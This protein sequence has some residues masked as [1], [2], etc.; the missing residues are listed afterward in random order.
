[1]GV[2]FGDKHD[3]ETDLRDNTCVEFWKNRFCLLKEGVG[4]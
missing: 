4:E 2:F 3:R 1:M